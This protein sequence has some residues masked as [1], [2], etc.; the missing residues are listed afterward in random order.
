ME[1]RQF[2]I[3]SRPFTSAHVLL[4]FD[5]VLARRQALLHELRTDLP[6]LNSLSAS[7]LQDAQLA[8]ENG[9]VWQ[10]WL[11]ETPQ[12]SLRLPSRDRSAPDLYEQDVSRVRQAQQQLPA[13]FH[14]ALSPARDPSSDERTAS[15]RV[16]ARRDGRNR[17]LR[18]ASGAEQGELDL[19]AHLPS[20]MPLAERR[21]VL[22]RVLQ[23]TP[24]W[25]R[26]KL[27]ESLHLM[28]GD[29]LHLAS[30]SE[31]VMKRQG[32]FRSI[33]N[34]HRLQSAMDARRILSVEVAVVRNWADG[35]PQHLELVDIPG[36]SHPI[37]KAVQA[38]G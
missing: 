33:E 21:Q 10:A 23:L 31:L 35:T 16:R 5:Q 30:G 22:L 18:I 15:L 9:I 12:L 7:T 2:L 20:V 14:L 29:A 6:C 36:T 24:N 3:I 32:A 19:P 4:A 37:G 26:V 25:A 11:Q 13:Q 34:G 27:T 1:L 38:S 8:T 17:K 28:A